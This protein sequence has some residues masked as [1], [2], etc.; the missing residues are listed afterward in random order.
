MITAAKAQKAIMVID[1]ILGLVAINQV[2]KATDPALQYDRLANGLSRK[3]KKDFDE[4]T[5][6]AID[7]AVN[8]ITAKKAGRITQNEYEGFMTAFEFRLNEEFP[9]DMAPEIRTAVLKSYAAGQLSGLAPGVKAAFNVT[10]LRTQEFITSHNVYWVGDHF[11]EKIRASVTSTVFDGLNAGLGRKELGAFLQHELGP[12]FKE[13]SDQYWNVVSSAA[14]QTSRNM[15]KVSTYEITG[16]QAIEFLNPND[17]RTSDICRYM[18]GTTWEVSSIIGIRD[19]YISATNPDDVKAA[20]PWLSFE[21]IKSMGGGDTS[22]EDPAKL[23]AAGVAIPPLHGLCRSSLV[24]SLI[25]AQATHVGTSAAPSKGS[26]AA[27][28]ERNQPKVSRSATAAYRSNAP[29][30]NDEARSVEY[31]QRFESDPLYIMDREENLSMRSVKPTTDVTVFPEDIARIKKEGIGPVLVEKVGRT[32][33]IVDGNKRYAAAKEAGY[34]AI[35]VIRREKLGAPAVKR[36]ASKDAQ[37]TAYKESRERWQRSFARWDRGESEQSYYDNDKLISQVLDNDLKHEFRFGKGQFH[38]GKR[39][40]LFRDALP[41]Y[42]KTYLKEEQLW[43]EYVAEHT[44]GGQVNIKRGLIESWVW[45]E[46]YLDQAWKKKNNEIS[47][48]LIGAPSKMLYRANY[49]GYKLIQDKANGMWA[50]QHDYKNRNIRFFGGDAS[51]YHTM[52]HEFGHLIDG[53]LSS[54]RGLGCGN[55][56]MD[57]APDTGMITKAERDRFMQKFYKTWDKHATGDIIRVPIKNDKG[58]IVGHYK[59]A[60]GN[61][62]RDYQGRMY[63]M[64][65]GNTQYKNNF[66]WAIQPKGDLSENFRP[67]QLWADTAAAVLEKHANGSAFNYDRMVKVFGEDYMK[68]AERL[69]NKAR[70][71]GEWYEQR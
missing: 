66:D 55:A 22:P 67:L 62:R 3:L 16:V 39:Y 59:R 1:G 43:A 56:V 58:E 69:I 17:E 32:W 10:D 36:G 23:A 71:K 44:P 21:E 41:D 54:P 53:I 11:D 28:A 37:W 7:E 52:N 65:S 4:K 49:S 29:K 31:N 61:W 25:D 5:T 51:D 2:N 64:A 40:V 34:K 14:V 50:G 26:P 47:R 57:W 45:N 24:I 68:A 19:K 70:V 12:M 8:I 18:D 9:H 42:K 30:V 15:G 38:G 27:S 33:S 13:R 60:A 6:L 20:A 63:A 35:P 48:T 46:P